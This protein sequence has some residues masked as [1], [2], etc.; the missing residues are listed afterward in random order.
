MRLFKTV[1]FVALAAL[2]LAPMAACVSSEDVED[3]LAG[4]LETEGEDGKAD[5]ASTFTYFEI[6]R[7]F[8]RCVSPLC[9]G[10]WVSRV[11]REGLKCSDGLTAERCYV[12]EIDHTALGFDET[13]GGGWVGAIENRSMIFRGDLK[14]KTYGDFGKLGFLVT[15]EAWMAGTESVAEGVW[16][17]VEQSGVR[18][19]AAPCADKIER[20]LNS[21]RTA[22]ISALD[23]VPSGATEEAEAIAWAA[24]TSEDG[25]IVVGDR[26]TD[27]VDGRTAKARTVTQFFT[28]LLPAGDTTQQP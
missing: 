3:D 27:R 5:G 6:E 14:K 18:C 10:Y 25:L 11:N 2:S 28:R 23:F 13:D 7:D 17:K 8:R 20:K 16:V 21:T 12:A 4:E 9:G 15:S 24:L 26:Y 1:S 19:F 22:M